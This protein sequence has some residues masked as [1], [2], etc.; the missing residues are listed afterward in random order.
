MCGFYQWY[1]LIGATSWHCCLWF[2]WVKQIM[3]Y[4]HTGWQSIIVLNVYWR[5]EQYV[6]QTVSVIDVS[7]GNIS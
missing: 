5:I 2:S 1:M 4:V 3:V 6:K 7:V